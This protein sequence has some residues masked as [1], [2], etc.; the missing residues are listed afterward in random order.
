MQAISQSLSTAAEIRCSLPIP[1]QMREQVAQ[2]FVKR[3]VG[4]H[5]VVSRLWRFPFVALRSAPSRE[6][7]PFGKRS[8]FHAARAPGH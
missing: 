8:K 6:P 4:Q 1:L 3:L 2:R 7:H 5:R